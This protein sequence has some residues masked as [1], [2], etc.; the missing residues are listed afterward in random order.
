M[1]LVLLTAKPCC[2]NAYRIRVVDH[3]GGKK[4][5]VIAKL[6][7]SLHPSPFR[8]MTRRERR[9]N[10]NS[11]FL[12]TLQ[13]LKES[14]EK[15]VRRTQQFA[16]NADDDIFDY[17][18]DDEY[19]AHVAKN[20]SSSKKFIVS[21]TDSNDYVDDGEELWVQENAKDESQKPTKKKAA[22]LTKKQENRISSLL[23]RPSSSTPKQSKPGQVI[24]LHSFK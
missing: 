17:L 8:K 12:S 11:D 24:T 7:F 6:L 14:R 10:A 19:Y 23:L 20:R 4:W 22:Q 18:E 9:G 15:G 16:S 21:D 5:R 2:N 13:Q 1:H 3:L